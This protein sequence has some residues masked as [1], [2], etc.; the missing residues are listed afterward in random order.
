[1]FVRMFKHFNKI[2]NTRFSVDGAG[3][4]S[5]FICAY[6]FLFIFKSS[7]SSGVFTSANQIHVF[8][9]R[10]SVCSK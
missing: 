1:M 3:E 9:R 6:T 2:I 10:R 4:I 5:I 7:L 8:T